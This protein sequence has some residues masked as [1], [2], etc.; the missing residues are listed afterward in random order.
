MRIL[1]TNMLRGWGGQS[2]R[3]LVEMRGA[4]RAGHTVALAAPHMA[5][6]LAKARE[7]G[8]EPWPGYEFK[9]PFQL[10][11]SV[12][13]T[14]RFLDDVRRFKPDLVHLHGSQDTWLAVL[15]RKLAPRDVPLLLRTKHNDYPWSRHGG[16]RWLY[17]QVDAYLSISTFI[18]KQILDYPRLAAKP[19]A[20]IRSVPD[21]SLLD[22]LP[23]PIRDE[24][25]GLKPGMFLWVSTARMR[26]EKAHE[27]T[28]RAFAKVRAARPDAFLLIA[29]A[30]S[31]LE[32]HRALAARLGLGPDAAWLPGFRKDVPALLAS[33]DAYV[34]ASRLEGLG[35]AILEA[36]A[37]G[38][39]TV[40]TNVG[41]IPDS[42]IHERTGLLVP[43]EEPETLAAAML[44]IM[45]DAELRRRLSEGA[46]AH[47]REQ[48]D[49]ERLVRE[50]VAYYERL[51]GGAR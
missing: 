51:L 36:L 48:F 9:P 42:V 50:T 26:P 29:G 46:R 22:A 10:W 34:L 21:P 5:P 6:L 45:G 13:D 7:A 8:V 18:Q 35:T 17:N 24:V 40:A 27:I 38:L 37:A 20:L 30:G 25:P 39:P 49:E 14:R 23:A 16:N 33:A 44:R 12:P 31:L 3:I 11:H 28:L 32:D 1:H 15:A 47:V 19:H 4:V 2:N 41:G 43:P